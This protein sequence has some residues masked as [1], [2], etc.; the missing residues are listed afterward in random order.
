MRYNIVGYNKQL[1]QR[2][3]KD[4][5]GWGVPYYSTTDLCKALAVYTNAQTQT[6]F[7]CIVLWRDNEV[8]AQYDK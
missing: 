6:A 3:G 8:M 7:D 1:L 5:W 2:N 4:V